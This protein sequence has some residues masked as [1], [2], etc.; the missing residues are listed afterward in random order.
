MVTMSQKSSLAQYPQSVSQVLKPD[1]VQKI[2]HVGPGCTQHALEVAKDV[3]GL[4][5]DI[6]G[7]DKGAVRIGRDLATDEDDV[8]HPPAVRVRLGPSPIPVTGRCDMPFFN[9]DGGNR[10][11]FQKQLLT[12][13]AGD[14]NI[15]VTGPGAVKYSRRTALSLSRKAVRLS[16]GPL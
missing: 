2:A 12:G 14:A 16:S 15:V 3:G 13:K 10:L 1:K 8:T 11:D 7:A 6:A 4:D 9:A 5:A